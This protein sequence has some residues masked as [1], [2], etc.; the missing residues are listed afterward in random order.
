MFWFRKEKQEPDVQDQ[1]IRCG[2]R[3]DGCHPPRPPHCPP[4]CPPGVTGPT[5]PQG[6]PGVT[7]PTGPQ[8]EP[9]ATGPTG[10]QGEPGATGPTGPTGAQ[11]PTGATGA[12]GGTS[13]F[14]SAYSTPSQ[15]G[16]SG[17]EL[18]FDRNAVANGTAVAHDQN[19]TD[20]TISQ[21]G[22]YFVSFHGTVSPAQGQNYPLAILV[23][24]QQQGSAVVGASAHS[25]FQ[26]SSGS[27]NISFTQII[28]VTTVPAV[29]NVVGTGGNYLYTEISMT[30]QKLAES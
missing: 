15:S 17:S 9:G 6:E 28:Q 30:I 16:S 14:L 12:S 5:G 1:N 23:N 10:P 4:P 3:P 27:S 8:G 7:G 21:P 29:V 19:S 11:G 20:F 25:V 24:L 26:D 22:Y 2:C 18:I 13:E